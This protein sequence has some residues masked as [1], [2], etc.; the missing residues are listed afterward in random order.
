MTISTV[1]LPVITARTA[2]CRECGAELINK[3][4]TA[5]HC[6]GKCRVAYYSKTRQAEAIWDKHLDRIE[7]L[8]KQIRYEW[9]D[10]RKE[11]HAAGLE[12]F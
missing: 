7:M 10:L 11:I 6:N 4:S 5:L 8:K 3:K 12:N 2:I 1:P 9:L